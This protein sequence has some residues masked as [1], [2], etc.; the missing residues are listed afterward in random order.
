MEHCENHTGHEE[1]FC[2][3]FKRYEELTKEDERLDNL[4]EQRRLEINAMNGK[5]SMA[6]GTICLTLLGVIV[7]LFIT[8]SAGH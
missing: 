7:Q 4:I 1:K 3:L 8:F 5:I 6:L 2:S